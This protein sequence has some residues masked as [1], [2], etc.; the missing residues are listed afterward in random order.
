[1]SAIRRS[2]SKTRSAMKSTEQL[3]WRKKGLIF[4]PKQNASDWITHY[5]ALPVCDLL[6]DD[7]LRIYFATRDEKG[8][9]RPTFIEVD[10]AN[11]E[12]IL[13]IHDR[14]ILEPGEQ[15][16]FDDNGIMPSSIVNVDGKKY[17]YYI[18]W[19]PQV[20]VSYRLSI[21]LA[22]SDDGGVTFRRYSQ[23]PICDRDMH[24]PFFN[25]A[26]YV[27]RENGEWK[28]WYVSC[29]GW[30]QIN[31]WPEP[32]YLIR[33]SESKDGIHWVRSNKECIGYDDFTH[34][35]GKPCVIKEN[36]LYRMYYSYRNSVGY[37]TDKEMTYRIGYAESA[38]GV[39]WQR[40]DARVDLKSDAQ[41]WE[42]EM[43]EYCSIYRF[44][45]KWYMVYNGNMFGESGF[46]Y[47][48]LDSHT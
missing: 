6:A 15:G 38:D 28:M 5:A 7:R 26:P 31:G 2:G 42:S 36:G 45:D 9:S 44:R 30:K 37:R 48:V 3:A 12:K 14:T 35:I 40:K 25:T 47:A 46:G 8:R 34:A 10:P 23:G 24:E 16:T 13:Y 19:N 27:I 20:T 11:P 17:L 21:G 29:T 22:I 43:Q 32:F 33:Y 18:G 41:G 4:D 1:M 39:T